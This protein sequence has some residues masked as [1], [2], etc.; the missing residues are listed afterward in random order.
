ME[1]VLIRIK[2]VDSVR[3]VALA[4]VIAIHTRP[5]HTGDATDDI[6][7][8][9]VTI[10]QLARFAVPFFFVISGYFWG[11]KIRS[12][13]APAEVTTAMANRI[14]VIFGVWSTF[15]ALPYNVAEIPQLGVLGYLKNAYWSVLSLL[16][17]PV[18]A[19]LQGTKSHLWF[20]MALLFPLGL[21]S[22]LVRLRRPGLLVVLAVVLYVIG[23][24]GKAYADTPF[25]IH[26]DFNTRNGPFFSTIFFVS[27][28]MLSKARPN[29]RWFSFGAILVVLGTGIHFIEL[30][31]LSTLYGSTS[32]PDFLVGTY[33][34]GVGMAILALSN[35]RCLQGRFVSE[36]GKFTLGI[37]A[38]H[39]FFVDLLRPVGSLTKSGFWEV[40]YVVLVLFLSIFT[41]NILARNETVRKVLM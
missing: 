22:L 31:Y 37:Y 3:I 30:Y 36:M 38:I 9:A 12:G 6:G 2:S 15:Y 34:T 24:L 7:S 39:Y 18:V 1:V 27:G 4:A 10:N 20:L 29:H 33:F 11:V 35:A 17:H 28:Y 19:V 41:V 16:R 21:G 5:F 32:L 8:L 26:T 25:G 13:A 40:G 23:L 14:L